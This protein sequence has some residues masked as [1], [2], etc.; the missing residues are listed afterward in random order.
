M[1]AALLPSGSAAAVAAASSRAAS[2]AQAVESATPAAWRAV[3][4]RVL[5]RTL[6]A[7]APPS[8][9]AQPVFAAAATAAILRR[10]ALAAAGEA[11]I[12]RVRGAAR[13]LL[14]VDA[15]AVLA[16]APARAALR[17]LA[18][19]GNTAVVVI[20]RTV[21]A[22]LA[23][24]LPDCDGLTLAAECGAFVRWGGAL[25]S[26]GSSGA[27]AA[28]AAWSCQ[29]P[30]CAAR[31][32]TWLRE[33]VPLFRYF[34]E[35]T[36][37]AILDVRE[38]SICFSYAACGL[39]E[40]AAQQARDLSAALAEIVCCLPA[41]IIASH[42]ERYVE[43]RHEHASKALL[44]VN[45]MR[46]FDG[47]GP[48]RCACAKAVETV[49]A[50]PPVGGGAAAASAAAVLIYLTAPHHPRDLT[51]V[52]LLLRR[53]EEATAGGSEAVL[54]PAG[55]ALARDLRV[56]LPRM[57]CKTCLHLPST[58]GDST[59]TS[60][61]SSA[62]V[63][64]AV[65]GSVTEI[66]GGDN[67]DEED[68]ER[69]GALGHVALPPALHLGAYAA[70]HEYAADGKAAITALP[71]RAPA[72]GA[73]SPVSGG[74]TP[75]VSCGDDG[76]EA[77]EAIAGL[78][79]PPLPLPLLMPPLA[80]RSG[81]SRQLLR[82]LPLPPVGAG[83]ASPTAAPVL[84]AGE[85][86]PVQPLPRVAAATG[87]AATSSLPPPPDS[88]YIDVAVGGNGGARFAV[89]SAGEAAELLAAVLLACGHE[90]AASAAPR[91]DACKQRAGGAATGG[92][93]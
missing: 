82:M 43:M 45:A 93:A 19:T 56:L 17:S 65:S 31:S 10:P 30:P 39:A 71:R 74:A 9:P 14:I 85:A 72:A 60:S 92:A 79:E 66:A 53:L 59:L 11:I 67:A 3:V 63:G 6:A 62:G 68:A 46:R 15:E 29:L 91:A 52:N 7:G 24:A 40:F 55:D 2:L 36:P 4:L 42:G 22:Q 57:R 83:G 34:H 5:A 77:Y 27:T 75:S 12:A 73:A 84:A 35:R 48:L 80:S 90:E 25:A 88:R 58:S 16:L 69:G 64:A 54:A 81:S 23:A 37:G 49:A 87:S 1:R 8:S 33:V 50:T 18:A 41:V 89:T 21:R 78:F 61:S 44:V 13:R 86:A 32:D 51:A 38:A 47:R 20:A 76:G 70:S 26:G 28:D